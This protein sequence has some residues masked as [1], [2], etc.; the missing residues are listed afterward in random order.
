MFNPAAIPIVYLLYKGDSAGGPV[1]Y[2][3][4]I[5]QT[6]LLSWAAP[7]LAHSTQTRFA[8]RT[9]SNITGLTERNTDARV[10]IVVGP[11]GEDLSVLPPAPVGLTARPKAGGTALVEWSYPFLKLAALPLG[12]HVYLT[13]GS[14]PSYAVPAATVAYG[15]AGLPAGFQRPQAGTYRT[16]LTGLGDGVSYVVAVRAYSATGEETNLVTAAVTGDTTPPLNVA[17]LTA[18]LASG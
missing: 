17:S 12:F 3:H 1:D 5:K 8:V 14:V 11:A 2:S 13:A 16:T 18:T 9:H 10:L 15:P 6:A 7:P 4:A